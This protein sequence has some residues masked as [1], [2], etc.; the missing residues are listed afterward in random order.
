[1][2]LFHVN[3]LRAQALNLNSKIALVMRIQNYK[4][5]I[6]TSHHFLDP[7]KRKPLLEYA[8]KRL[9]LLKRTEVLKESQVGVHCVQRYTQKICLDRLISNGPCLDN[10]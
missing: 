8:L 4:H 6:P 5:L 9:P 3:E 2:P 7:Q 1:M 10:C